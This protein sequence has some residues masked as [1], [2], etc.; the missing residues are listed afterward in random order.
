MIFELLNEESMPAYID[1][2]GMFNDTRTFFSLP[3]M[4]DS[5]YQF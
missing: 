2:I 5:M 3:V 4:N 1:S